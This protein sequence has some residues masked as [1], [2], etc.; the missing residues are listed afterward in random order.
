MCPVSHSRCDDDCAIHA[1]LQRL[2]TFSDG[3]DRRTG[4]IL[5]SGHVVATDNPVSDRI[6]WHQIDKTRQGHADHP[7]MSQTRLSRLAHFIP[8]C[9]SPGAFSSASAMTFWRPLPRLAVV[10]SARHWLFGANTLWNRA[11]LPSASDLAPP[12]E[13]SSGRWHQGDALAR[14]HLAVDQP[15]VGRLDRLWALL[16]FKVEQE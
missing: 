4:D 7:K 1:S 11:E 15:V 12:S 6:D 10:T 5:T 9:F 2:L 13:A 8:A 3:V 14:R 16:I